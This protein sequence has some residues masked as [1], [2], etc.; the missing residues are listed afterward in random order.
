MLYFALTYVGTGALLLV[1]YAWH[2]STEGGELA[3]NRAE[4]PLDGAKQET[5]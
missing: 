1:L 5:R 3:T 4:A 2:E